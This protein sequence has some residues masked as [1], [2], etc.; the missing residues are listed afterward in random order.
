MYNK[1]GKEDHQYPVGT[2]GGLLR[3]LACPRHD[4]NE[5]VRLGR[6]NRSMY[7]HVET[8]IVCDVLSL[9]P[10]VILRGAVGTDVSAVRADRT[11]SEHEREVRG[12][13]GF[14]SGFLAPGGSL[15]A[16]G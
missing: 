7:A 13:P 1:Q 4:K 2:W 9:R 12:Y 8:P 16:G 15:Q 5:A 10:A 14:E 6:R 11:G 3:P